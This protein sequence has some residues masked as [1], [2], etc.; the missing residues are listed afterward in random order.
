MWDHVRDFSQAENM[1][2]FADIWVDTAGIIENWGYLRPHPANEEKQRL[3]VPG[4]QPLPHSIELFVGV[5]PWKVWAALGVSI[6]VAI[7]VIMGKR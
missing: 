4:P 1:Y 7:F 3:I 2:D 6:A 5:F